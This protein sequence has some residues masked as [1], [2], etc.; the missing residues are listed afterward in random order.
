MKAIKFRAAFGYDVEAASN[1]SAVETVG[2]SLTQQ[3]MAEDADINV[4]MDRFGLTGR[5]PE[6]PRVPMYGD[7]DTVFDYQSALNAVSDAYDSF[8]ELPAKVRQRFDNNPQ[9][10]LEFLSHDDNMEEAQRLGLLR[11]KVDDGSGSPAAGSGARAPAASEGQQAARGAGQDGAGSP[12]RPA[13]GG[14]GAGSGSG[15]A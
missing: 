12:G 13:N 7:F 11:E 6:N 15:A 2:P 8:M 4:I 14:P 9:K 5:M 1:E 10:L 3:S